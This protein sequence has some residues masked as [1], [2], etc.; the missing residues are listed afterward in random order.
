[1]PL[2]HAER[3]IDD[4]VIV[5]VSGLPRSGTS[6]MMA[7]L[8]A[9]GMA[10][11]VDGARAADLDNPNGY[12]EFAPVKNI[13]KDQ[14]W[15]SMACGKVVKIVSHL[16]TNTPPTF[17][18]KIIFMRRAL[19]EILSSQQQMLERRGEHALHDDD[20]MKQLYEKHLQGIGEWMGGQP[21][22]D[23]LYVDY[24]TTLSNPIK[25]AQRLE[26]FLNTALNIE[27]MSAS[28]DSNLYRQREYERGQ[29]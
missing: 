13:A 22:I 7:M 3:N 29:T 15:L 14:A 20:K 2:N 23:V 28:V 9:G 16:L 1:M 6:M 12:F 11:L 19:P 17:T 8:E 24:A 26:A 4:G 21:H 18:Y 5:V 10:L 27:A 25:T